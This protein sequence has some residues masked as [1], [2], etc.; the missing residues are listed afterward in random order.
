MALIT[1]CPS[2]G[3]AF[4]ITPTLLQAHG[5]DVRCGRCAKV[6]NGF[7]TLATMQEPEAAVPAT[8]EAVGTP[9]AETPLDAS[10]AAPAV[11]PINNPDA[12]PEPRFEAAPKVASE[13]APRPD[14]E[15]AP[16]PDPE[17]APRTDTINSE[18]DLEQILSQRAY[19]GRRSRHKNP[20]AESPAA[21]AAAHDSSPAEPYISGWR[22][23]EESPTAPP[24]SPGYEAPDPDDIPRERARGVRENYAFDT[25]R[26]VSL[27]WSVAS[28]FLLIVLA[29]QAVYFYRN[30]I[31][32]TMPVAKPL[33]DRY[34]KLLGC[35]VQTPLR[36]ELLNIE[37]SEMRMDIQ[38]PGKI[39][40][41]AT[42]RNYAPYSQAFP[43][44][45]V[46]LADTRDQPIASRVFPPGSY[47]EKNE[48]QSS[49]VEPDREFNVQL[50]LDSGGVSA[51]GYRLSLVY[52]GS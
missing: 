11:A 48:I 28:F 44:F 4:R 1:R 45:E 52:P 5:G 15:P 37:S 7:S 14:P 3:T 20:S 13:A 42:V 31:V 19:S 49:T 39:I 35:T 21:A 29:A 43:S 51:T 16:K 46:T 36:P 2:C 9:P 40:L 8:A 50:H 6:F 47:L 32:D 27:F 17:P 18:T 24:R 38:D 34:C 10:M 41:N 12:I 22:Q 30:D 26:P 33:L 23:P 25:E